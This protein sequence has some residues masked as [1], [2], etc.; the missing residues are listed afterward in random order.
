MELSVLAPLPLH[1]FQL[2]FHTLGG[3]ILRKMRKEFSVEGR[4]DKMC[5]G[6]RV[7]FMVPQFPIEK[8]LHC[9]LWG[10]WVHHSQNCYTTFPDFP[11]CC[12]LSLVSQGFPQF[13]IKGRKKYKTSK[14]GLIRHCQQSEI[15]QPRGKIKFSDL[16]R[17]ES[18]TNMQNIL[19][20]KKLY[21]F[22]LGRSKEEKD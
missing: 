7:L 4:D 20:L 1:H 10:E 6:P 22:M 21:S 19:Y 8:V 15:I 2:N 14:S 12:M 18:L 16:W 11:L 3:L 5:V 17:K 13:S 9:F